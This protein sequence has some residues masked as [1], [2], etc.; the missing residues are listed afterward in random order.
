MLIELLSTWIRCVKDLIGVPILIHSLLSAVPVL[1]FRHGIHVTV[2]MSRACFC[3]FDQGTG[4]VIVARVVQAVPVNLAS[5]P[6]NGQ[7]L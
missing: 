1:R 7:L 6:V 2:P 5:H 4:V 3:S